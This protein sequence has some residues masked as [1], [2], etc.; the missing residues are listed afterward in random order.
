MATLRNS[1]FCAFLGVLCVLG[2]RLL[3]FV[4]QLSFALADIQAIA[5]NIGPPLTG[6]ALELRGAAREQRSY[7]K[8]TGKALAIATAD[9]GRLVKNTDERMG[10]LA[11]DAHDV[12]L[13]SRAAVA[14]VGLDADKLAVASEEQVN[15][16]GY[17]STLALAAARGNFE[18]LERLWPTLNRLAESSARSADNVDQATESV[19][20]ALEPLRKAEGRLKW[21]LRWLLGLPKINIH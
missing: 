5:D 7:Y 6:A 21:V 10:A 3:L 14:V 12:L 15:K 20:I 18:N 1:L 4:D 2:V 19:K 9:F 8:A 11:Q 17:E 13:T 16:V